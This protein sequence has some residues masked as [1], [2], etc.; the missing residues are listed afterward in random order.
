MA[1]EA[2]KHM[3]KVAGVKNMKKTSLVWKVDKTRQDTRQKASG[4]N[5]NEAIRALQYYHWPL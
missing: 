4:K 1:K 5:R 3:I 2:E